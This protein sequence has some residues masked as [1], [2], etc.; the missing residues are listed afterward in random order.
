[1][2]MLQLAGPPAATA[3][4]LIKLRDRAARAGP[5]ITDVAVSLRAFRS[6]RAAARGRH[7]ERVLEALLDYGD[8]AV[9]SPRTP[10]RDAP[11]RG[12]AARHDLAV[13]VESHRHRAAL[14]AAGA[15]RR[16]RSVVRAH[17]SSAA[18]TPARADASR[19]AAARPHDRDAARR[20]RRAKREAL[21]ADHEPRP[22]RVR[23]TCWAAAAGLSSARTASSGSRSRPDEIEYLAA[24]F[25][26]LARN[27][28]DVELMMFAQ[29]NSEH[30]RHKIFNAD[31]LDRRQARAEEPVRDDPQHVCARAGRCAVGVQGQ[32]GRRRRRRAEPLVLAGSR[33]RRLRLRTT[34]PCIS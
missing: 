5:A 13:G 26:A 30:C 32:R 15:P 34:S 6:R 10:A 22:D 19:A 14:L 3:F 20:T 8:G 31:W 18:L 25:A 24:Q 9:I 4:R 7:N 27:P 23:S 28:T 17:A 2:T 29:A 16:A 11:L 12:A 21:F 33:D 1:M